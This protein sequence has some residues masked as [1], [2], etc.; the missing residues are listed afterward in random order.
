MCLIIEYESM[1]QQP[2]Q[3]KGEKSIILVGD[4]TTHVAIMEDRR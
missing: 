1:K 3:L 4:F 2:A